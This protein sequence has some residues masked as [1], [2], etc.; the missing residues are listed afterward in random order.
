MQLQITKLSKKYL[1]GKVAVDNISLKL[2]NGMFGLL[3]PNGAGKTTF[4]KMLATLLEPTGGTVVYNG[5]R[6]GENNQAIRRSLG[7][8]P[9]TYDLYPSLSARELLNYMATLHGLPNDVS[10]RKRID[11]V[12][13]QVNLT[14]EAAQ[15]VGG[16]S[17]GMRQR[18]GI[19]QALLNNPELLI[20]DEPTA[21]LDPEERVR[22][23]NLLGRLSQERIVILST[24]IVG[25]INSSCDDMALLDNGRIH[26]RGQPTELI[27]QADGHVWQT[28]V[29]PA[30]VTDIE[31]NHNVVSVVRRTAGVTVRVLGDVETVRGLPALQPEEPTLED[32]YIWAMSSPHGKAMV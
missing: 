27:E 19:A 8:L 4:M 25:D 18:L 22:F 31:E 1:R 21:G 5:L 9:Q 14:D 28:T 2:N 29:P 23:R 15:K 10:R 16:F 32:A 13:E 3:G 17:G 6:L 11:A 26:F 12:L 24:H 20:V 30:Y 7:Y